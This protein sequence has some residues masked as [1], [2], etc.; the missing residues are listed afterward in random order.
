MKAI[1]WSDDLSVGVYIL[2]ADHQLLIRLIKQFNEAVSSRQAPAKI[3]K[4]LNGLYDYTDFHFIREEVLMTAC[5]FPDVPAHHAV[6]RKLCKQMKEIC[7]N[8]AKS[9]SK[10]LAQETKVFLNEW[11]TK[12][13]MG[14]D[15]QYAPSMVGK[16]LEIAAAHAPLVHQNSIVESAE[17][18][19]V[20]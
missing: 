8:Y 13:I 19:D 5:G 15:K 4:I 17:S 7:D 3:A 10:E 1:E 16:E 20:Y 18:T 11:L 12:H 6:H 9:P 2:D 14:H